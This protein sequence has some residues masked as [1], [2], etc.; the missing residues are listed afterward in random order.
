MDGFESTR[1]IRKMPEPYGC[2]PIIAL[3][4]NAMKEDIDKCTASG[5]T[6][7]LSKPISREHLVEVLNST[8][9][10]V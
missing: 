2:I 4:A 9:F 10:Q 5:M 8:V 1:K 7:Y 6:A 3:T